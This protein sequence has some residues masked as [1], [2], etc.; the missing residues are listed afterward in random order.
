MI[1]EERLVY[2]GFF[3]KCDAQNLCYFVGRLRQA[4]SMLEAMNQN[5][6]DY[7]DPQLRLHGVGR[8]AEKRLDMQMLFHPF[9]QKFDEPAFAI[10]QRD[11]PGGKQKMIGQER[12]ALAGGGID[13]ANVSKRP[14][15]QMSGMSAAKPDESVVCDA[16]GGMD[17]ITMDNAEAHG[18]FGTDD[19]EG[20]GE[21][22]AMKASEVE[23]AA[24]EDV[25]G[26]GE[27]RKL[28]ERGDVRGLGMRNPHKNRDLRVEIEKDVGFDGAFGTFETS[29]GKQGQAQ[30]DRGG[31]QRIGGSDVQTMQFRI[32]GKFQAS[33][34]DHRQRDVGEDAMIAKLIGVGERAAC[35]R[36]TE[37]QMISPRTDSAETR[38]RLTQTRSAGELGEDH[39]EQLIHAGER[40]W[41]SAAPMTLDRQ[42]EGAAG[43]EIQKLSKNSSALIH[44]PMSRAASNENQSN[45]KQLRG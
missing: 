36:V 24:I 27:K 30:I 26:V 32:G 38:D 3:A 14:T 16:C 18:A 5:Q 9:E 33:R 23:V 7:R 44:R 25:E 37:A 13:V 28:I 35:R 4:Q 34:S 45:E 15:S 41:A 10:E 11:L 29:P 43:K 20:V 2:Q 6:H 17:F 40:Q 22:D 1:V 31:I 19:E 21:M 12:Q 8:G 39:A 42:L